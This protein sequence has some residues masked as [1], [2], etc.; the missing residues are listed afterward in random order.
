MSRILSEIIDTL[1]PGT[2][3]KKV[4]WQIENLAREGGAEGLAF[5]SIVASG[6]NSA[7][8]HAVPTDRKI[9]TR[10]PITLDVGVTLDG[11]CCDMTRTVFIGGTTPKFKSIYGTVRRAQLAALENIRPGVKSI[12]PDSTARD[13]IRDAGFGEFFGHSLGHGVGLATHERPRLGPEK[14]VT[15]KEGMVV[16]DEPGI[17]IPGEGG[18]RLEEM[19]VIEKKGAR[20]LTKDKHF[21]EF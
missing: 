1:E 15:L 12:L 18:V 2:T 19:V 16:T 14:P 5:P 13:I 4:A 21:H 3:E 11:Y 20:V 10:E 9:R 7:L 6:P 17:Y 8:P